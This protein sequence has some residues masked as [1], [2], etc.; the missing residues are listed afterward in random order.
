MRNRPFFVG[1]ECMATTSRRKKVTKPEVK[2]D[3]KGEPIA[4]YWTSAEIAKLFDFDNIRSVQRLVENGIIQP[5]VVVE[6]GKN[7]SRYDLIPTVTGYVKNLRDKA[8]GRQ[9]TATEKD[10]KNQKLKAEIA[11]K[12]SQGEL[13]KLKTEIAM[14]RYLSVEEIKLN[15]SKFFIMIRQY[16]MNLPARVTGR[17]VGSITPIEAR[18]L[19]TDLQKELENQLRTFVGAARIEGEPEPEKKPAKRTAKKKPAAKKATTAKKTT[20][21]KTVTKKPTKSAAKKPVKK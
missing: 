14:G 21:K 20:A 8:A 7:V 3:T 12:E 19:E 1:E 9:S 2:E 13:H 11:L 6:N 18:R 5:T 10:L 16:V 17:L 4:Q 15:Y